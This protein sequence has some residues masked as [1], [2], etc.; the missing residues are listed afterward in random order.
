M[1]LS[2]AADWYI[3]Q[4]QF[5]LGVEDHLSREMLLLLDRESR[6]PLRVQLE[7]ALR[8]AVRSGRLEAGAKLPSTRTL[9]A[10]LGVSRG[11]VVEAYEQLVAEGYL[12]GVQGSGT[13]VSEVTHE[14]EIERTAP[15]QG[16]RPEYDFAPG[17]PDTTLVGRSRW[18]HHLRA[19][20]VALDGDGLQYGD[21]AGFPPLRRALAAYLAR[22]R[23][24]RATADRILICSGFAGA[25]S[26]LAH[27]L[28]QR[29]FHSIAMENPGSLEVHPIVRLAGLAPVPVRVDADGVD[30]EAVARSGA[31]LALL[32]PAH[33]F[34]T[35]VVLS[36]ERRAALVAWVR[37]SAGFLIEDDYDAEYRY[38]RL[39]IGATQGL[40]PEHVVCAGSLSKT[41]APALRLGWL[42]LPGHLVAEASTLRRQMDLGNPT[43]SQAAFAL[44]LESGDYDRHLRRARR[45][46]RQRRNVL[47]K[48]LAHAPLRLTVSGAAAGLHLV[49]A[50]P[51]PITETQMIDAG[52]RQGVGLYGLA[53]YRLGRSAGPPQ[54]LVIGYGGLDERRFVP[55]LRRFRNALASIASRRE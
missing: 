3:L 45:A 15:T 8:D 48:T 11:L 2:V 4:V 18:L 20:F 14:R 53:R 49:A 52:T 46:Y 28:V 26:L 1:W 10:D 50:L 37:E 16:R 22:V 55:A 33:Q 43:L 12:S 6:V 51:A 41:L 29:G 35:G 7:A 32:T 13:I 27:L 36:A 38:D 42:V 30:A 34:P 9:A 23:G 17:V 19:A 24:I 54:A 31:R 25:V 40:A 21:P 44:M 47:V 5:L 39:P